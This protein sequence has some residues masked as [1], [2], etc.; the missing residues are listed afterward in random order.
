MM[1]HRGKQTGTATGWRIAARWRRRRALAR[2]A[3]DAAAA[4]ALFVAL[5]VTFASAPTSAN[6]HYYPGSATQFTQPGT[7]PAVTAAIADEVVR[8]IVEIATTSSANAPDAVYRR[9]S[10]AAAWL[11]LSFAFSV[12]AAVNLAFVRHMRRAYASPRAKT[13][14]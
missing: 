12:L 10:S 5:S 6:P 3:L 4:F 9:T 11:L 2:P 1:G 7:P 14:G 8:P 13:R